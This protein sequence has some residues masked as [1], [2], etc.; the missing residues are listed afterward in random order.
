MISF[1]YEIDFTMKFGLS[2]KK[3]LIEISFHFTI[4]FLIF[5]MEK[6]EFKLLLDKMRKTIWKL[7]CMTKSILSSISFVEIILP[8]NQKVENFSKQLNRIFISSS[9]PRWNVDSAFYA[10]LFVLA[11]TSIFFMVF[12]ENLCKMNLR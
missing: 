11:Q 2:W 1:F 12:E 8:W 9:K 4:Y 6:Q 3:I 7:S 5:W 10:F